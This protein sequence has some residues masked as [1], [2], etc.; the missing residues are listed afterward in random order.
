[1]GDY[2]DLVTQANYARFI[3]KTRAR[4]CQMIKAKKI[5][6]VYLTGNKLVRLVE[7]ELSEYNKWANSQAN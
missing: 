3:G 2:R 1:M 4:V 7:P 6:A 5:T